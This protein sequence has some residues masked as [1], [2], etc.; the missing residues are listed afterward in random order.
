ML[1]WEKNRK[2]EKLFWGLQNEAI[3]GL[4]IRASFRDFK[5]GQLGLQKEAAL[6]ISNRVRYF[7]SGQTDF[8]L[9]QRLQTGERGIS[10][11][12]RD[13]KSGQALQ[14]G[15]EYKY[16]VHCKKWLVILRHYL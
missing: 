10:N 7:K 15:A 6:G 13:Y 5:L 14:I 2:V 9:G 8:R 12:G 1:K 4:Q 16:M 3:T 11:H